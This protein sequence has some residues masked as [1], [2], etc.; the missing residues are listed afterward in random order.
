MSL[1][2]GSCC[3]CNFAREIVSKDRLILKKYK[4]ERFAARAN[5]RKVVIRAGLT[6]SSGKIFAKDFT[7]LGCSSLPGGTLLTRESAGCATLCRL[8]VHLNFKFTLFPILLNR[9]Q[10]AVDT[11]SIKKSAGNGFQPSLPMGFNVVRCRADSSQSS[12]GICC[13]MR[14]SLLPHPNFYFIF[15]IQSVVNVRIEF[16]GDPRGHSDVYRCLVEVS[17]ELWNCGH[18]NGTASTFMFRSL[19]SIT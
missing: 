4:I 10:H 2:K 5:A 17:T 15:L 11:V 7:R 12:E 14:Q 1:Q 13:C 9:R 3:R 16:V 6:R 19:Y 18:V 8:L